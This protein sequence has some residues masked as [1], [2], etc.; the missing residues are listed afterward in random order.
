MAMKQISKE[1]QS[2]SHPEILSHER[3][4]DLLSDRGFPKEELTVKDKDILVQ[5]CYRFIVPL[6]QR[7]SNMRRANRLKNNLHP[8]K[9]NKSSSDTESVQNKPGCKR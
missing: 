2:L 7:V 8:F 4:V 5:M 6:P 3:L 9:A 1:V